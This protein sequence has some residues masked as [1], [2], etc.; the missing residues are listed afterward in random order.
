LTLNVHHLCLRE[1]ILRLRH[2]RVSLLRCTPIFIIRVVKATKTSDSIPVTLPPF[3]LTL[4]KV[5]HEN[6][7]PLTLTRLGLHVRQGALNRLRP[8]ANARLSHKASRRR[9]K[10]LRLI[11]IASG[12]NGGSGGSGGGGGGR[13]AWRVAYTR[14]TRRLLCS[15][16]TSPLDQTRHACAAN[17]ISGWRD[18]SATSAVHWNEELDKRRNGGRGVEHGCGAARA[19]PQREASKTLQSYCPSR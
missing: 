2:G 1:N 4:A 11:R 14:A 12:G 8:I 7:T 18:Q 17:A 3:P 10:R 16:G 9:E 19:Q 13:K 5:M 15:R 6:T